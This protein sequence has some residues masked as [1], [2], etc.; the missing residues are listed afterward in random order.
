MIAVAL[1]QVASTSTQGVAAW[2][3]REV[4]GRGRLP[5][6]AVVLSEAETELDLANGDRRSGWATD[7][8]WRAWVP[9]ID[10]RIGTDRTIDVRDATTTSVVT[11]EGFGLQLRLRWSLADAVFNDSVLRVDKAQRAWA[12]ARWRA[13]DRLVQLYFRRLELELTLHEA[14]TPAALLQAARLD[15]LLRAATGGR[16]R[17]GDRAGNPFPRVRR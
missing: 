17:Y 5:A 2:L 14:P 6:L 7:V 4:A 1:A 3:E 9:T 16:A 12:E 15:G 13:R 11:G 8:R 10:A